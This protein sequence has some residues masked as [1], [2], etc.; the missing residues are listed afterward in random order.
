MFRVNP[1][2][3][4]STRIEEAAFSDLGFQERYD[5]QEWIADNPSILGDDLLII[6]KE[7]SGFDLTNER[8]D[9]L[10][11]DAD[12]K[13]VVIELKRDDSGD[14]AYWQAIKYASYF[15]RA[16]P[17]EIIRVYSD[18]MA[19]TVQSGDAEGNLL[20]HLGNP[21]NLSG[22]NNDQRII[23]ASRRFAPEVTS[24]AFWINEKARDLITCVQL[25]PYK[26]ADSLYIQ[27]DTVLPIPGVETVGIA[28]ARDGGGAGKRSRRESQMQRNRN[29]DVTRF[30]GQVA[31][32][33]IDGLSADIKPDE[34]SRHAVGSPNF[35]QYRLWYKKHPWRNWSLCYSVHLKRETDASES[36]G[37]MSEVRFQYKTTGNWAAQLTD[38]GV[39]ELKVAL[40]ELSL[41]NGSLPN[42]QEITDT[43]FGGISFSLP[44]GPLDDN[45]ENA[46]AGELVKFVESI[47]PIVNEIEEYANEEDV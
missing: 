34:R 39:A 4:E 35:R 7:F 32:R 26:D 2:T 1:E 25:T 3:R 29:D 42:S 43:G 41:P 15:R 22:L 45:L 44:A 24:A 40:G 10:A 11:V 13:I 37:W 30:L 36:D 12:G 6:G 23:L 9:L 31:D 33:A 47:T 16:S 19:K 20:E 14:N 27:A 28:D 17:E 46:L 18:Y 38:A 21:E 8:L 5:I